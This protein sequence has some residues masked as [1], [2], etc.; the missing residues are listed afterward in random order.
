LRACMSILLESEL[1]WAI[2]LAVKHTSSDR[3]EQKFGRC[4]LVTVDTPKISH[5]NTFASCIT[6]I[7]F[8][9]DVT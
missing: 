9:R 1:R 3:G 4:T 5:K 2:A 8:F 7:E 6:R